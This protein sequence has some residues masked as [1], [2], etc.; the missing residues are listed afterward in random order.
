ML[1]FTSWISLSVHVRN[2][3]QLQRT[4]HGNGIVNG[5]SEK[6]KIFEAMKVVR[7]LATCVRAL[8]NDLGLFWK[9]SQFI[10]PGAKG[11]F[12]NALSDLRHVG[13]PKKQ[14]RHLR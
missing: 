9:R 4:I 1:G 13:G 3:L 7:K 12:G 11:A 2:F 5:A 10:E 14:H 8:Q 6:K